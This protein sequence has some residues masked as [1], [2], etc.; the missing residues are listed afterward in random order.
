LWADVGLTSAEE[1]IERWGSDDLKARLRLSD[2]LAQM[3]DE[4]KLEEE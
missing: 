4:L 1:Q 2:E 3:L